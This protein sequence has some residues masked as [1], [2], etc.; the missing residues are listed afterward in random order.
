[1]GCCG[2]KRKLLK[3]T[4]RPVRADRASVRQ[5]PGNAEPPPEAPRAKPKRGNT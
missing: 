5:M 1:M 4:R 3:G 2:E